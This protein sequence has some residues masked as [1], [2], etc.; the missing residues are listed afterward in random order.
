MLLNRL[1]LPFSS[2]WVNA[3]V[4]AR[5]FLSKKES[6]TS[7]SSAPLNAPKTELYVTHGRPSASKVIYYWVL[8]YFQNILNRFYGYLLKS[9]DFYEILGPQ[10][11]GEQFEKILSLIESGKQE[12]ARLV[13]GG[14]KVE[15]DGFFIQPTVFAD[16]EDNMRIAKEEIFGPVMQII[17]FKTLDEVI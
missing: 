16:V 15:G 6:T 7:L 14:D 11:D 9:P 1:T 5:D 4:P 2:T 10:I 13:A 3:V 17:K 8:I 12:G